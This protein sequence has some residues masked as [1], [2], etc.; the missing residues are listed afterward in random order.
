MTQNYHNLDQIPETALRWHEAGKGA[1]IATVVSTWGSAPRA[2]GSQMVVSRAGDMVGSVSG[3]CVEAAVVSAAQDTLDDGQPRLLGFGVADETAFA[4]GL[5]CGGRIEVLVEPIGVHA[6]AIAPSLLSAL[7]AA[8]AARRPVACRTD[9]ETWERQLLDPASPGEGKVMV[10][11]RDADGQMLTLYAPPLRLIVI[12]AVHISQML[13]PM[14]Q[15]AGF[16]PIIIDPRPAFAAATRFAGAEVLEDWP[17]VA[18]ARLAPDTSSAVVTLT[19]DAKI[20]DPAIVAALQ[21]DVFYLGCLG[22]RRTHAQ[23]LDRLRAL[24]LTQVQCARIH[25]PVGLPIGARG[26]AEIA[27][28]ILAQIIAQ[29]RTGQTV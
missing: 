16:A 23:R 22:S 18:L 24:G 19:H 7:V 13:V 27:V 21:S 20:D 2:A 29:R 17:D 8:R 28:A 14:A 26:P 6:P 10:S 25:G 4:V 3:G 9:L 12:G 5:A 1:A 11:G 15:M